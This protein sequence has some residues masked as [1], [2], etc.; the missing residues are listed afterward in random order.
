MMACP[1]ALVRVMWQSTCGSARL[2]G[3]F[4]KEIGFAIARLAFQSGPIDRAPVE[5]RRCPG[6]EPAKR[7][8]EPLETRRQAYA[9]RLAGP[10]GGDAIVADMDQAAQE[11]S[12]GEHGRSA[13]EPLCAGRDDGLNPPGIR[14]QAQPPLLRRS[15]NSRSRVA[16]PAWQGDNACGRPGREVHA[17]PDPWRD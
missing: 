6:F 3:Q 17:P 5:P 11:G 4:R 12:S 10:P 15:S 8:T 14:R 16:L 2:V 1:T 9:R 13:I 7:K